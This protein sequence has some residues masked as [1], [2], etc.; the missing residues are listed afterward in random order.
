MLA[1]LPRSVQDFRRREDDVP[2]NE[3]FYPQGGIKNLGSLKSVSFVMSSAYGVL[4]VTIY[5]PVDRV[6]RG[7]NQLP[8]S[9]AFGG[10]KGDF[11]RA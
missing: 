11:L 6:R 1:F 10:L 5:A 8:Y 2:I 7:H 4:E 9:K 3:I